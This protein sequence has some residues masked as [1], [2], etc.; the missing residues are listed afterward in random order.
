MERWILGSTGQFKKNKH[1]EPDL[2][3][4]LI[5]RNS[6]HSVWSGIVQSHVSVNFLWIWSCKD[7]CYAVIGELNF[8]LFLFDFNTRAQTGSPFLSLSVYVLVLWAYS[9][10]KSAE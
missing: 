4:P 10:W 1:I 7:K 3:L 5:R 6:T 8:F 9:L 2:T